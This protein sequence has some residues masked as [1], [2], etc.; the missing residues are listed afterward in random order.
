MRHAC[1]SAPSVQP[2]DPWFESSKEA[3]DQAVL[4]DPKAAAAY[5]FMGESYLTVIEL[6]TAGRMFNQVL[7]LNGD[8]VTEAAGRWRLVQKIQRAKPETVTGKKMALME[9]VT[10][11]DMALLLMEEMKIDSLYALRTPRPFSK[12]LE[13]RGKRTDSS[14]KAGNGCGHCRPSAAGRISKGSSGS[15]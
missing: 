14:G 12:P 7:D 2:N 3:F 1:E 15:G 11:A 9:R 10:R 13:D 6:E 4:I 8:Y 5:Y